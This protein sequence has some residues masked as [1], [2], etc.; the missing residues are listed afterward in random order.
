MII[1][2]LSDHATWILNKHIKACS[3]KNGRTLSWRNRFLL[4]LFSIRY[5][6][7]SGFTWWLYLLSLLHRVRMNVVFSTRKASHCYKFAIS[8]LVYL[9]LQRNDFLSMLGLIQINSLLLIDLLYFKALILP[10]RTFFINKPHFKLN[11][12]K[13]FKLKWIS[14]N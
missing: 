4:L 1:I 9:Y 8:R 2:L 13:N 11:N 14:T 12:N 7:T 10:H 6:G 5:S 3:A